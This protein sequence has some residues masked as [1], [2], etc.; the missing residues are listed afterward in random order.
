[1]VPTVPMTPTRPDVVACTRAR[2]P[3]SI[4][5]D[6]RHGQVG[7][8][9][10]QRRRRGRVA[11]HDDDLDVVLLH[12]VPRQLAGEGAHLGLRPGAVGVAAGV[13]EVDEVLV[14]EQ[15]EE[16]P[17]HGEPTEAGVEHA[18]GPGRHQRATL[19]NPSRHPG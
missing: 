10:G 4:T 13:A 12:Q 17:G 19:R 16:G 14:G 15:V 11:G 7:G 3:G 8:Q 5:L 2:T 6:Q 9:V 18:E 1:M